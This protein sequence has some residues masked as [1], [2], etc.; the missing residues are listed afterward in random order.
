[1]T[2]EHINEELFA[3]LVELAQLELEP[4]EA[5]YL[6]GELNHQLAALKELAQIPLPED[7]QPSTWGLQPQTAGPR[8]DAVNAYADPGRLIALAPEQED[9]Y[10]AVPDLKE[11]A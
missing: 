2:P 6:R 3:H 1:M 11:A 4:E 8:P 9:G 5:E 7:S 10:I